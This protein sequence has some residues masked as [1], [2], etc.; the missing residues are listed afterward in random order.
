MYET[1]E[2]YSDSMRE[3]VEAR[4]KRIYASF[5]LKNEL[6]NFIVRY[7]PDVGGA[8]EEYLA[9]ADG[10]YENT[11]RLTDILGQIENRIGYLAEKSHDSE[12]DEEYV[13]RLRILHD[14]LFE[15][16]TAP[17]EKKE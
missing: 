3:K 16:I 8:R 10:S 13:E 7:I 1:R 9:A 6:C 11:D 12:E 2:F 5:D 14:E 15:K 4:R 17:P